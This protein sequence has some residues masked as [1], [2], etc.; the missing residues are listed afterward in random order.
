MTTSLHDFIALLKLAQA[1]FLLHPHDPGRI[2]RNQLFLR[3]PVFLTQLGHKVSL[4]FPTF[5]GT[6]D[7]ASSQEASVPKL[8][9]FYMGGGSPT[10]FPQMAPLGTEVVTV[11]IRTREEV[12]FSLI[13]LRCF[14]Q[15]LLACLQDS[16]LRQDSFSCFRGADACFSL[17]KAIF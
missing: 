11:L 9:K 12:I 2:V 14:E 7:W 13:V 16:P 1:D 4:V 6:T 10:S 15:L 3:G 17:F 8:H 5:N